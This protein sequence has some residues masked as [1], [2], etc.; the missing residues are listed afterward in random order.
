MLN[1]PYLLE[2][3]KKIEAP[4][5]FIPIAGA[6]LAIAA[7][8]YGIKTV[9][10][11]G[12]SGTHNVKKYRV[13]PTPPGSVLFFGHKLLLGD[14]PAHKIAEWHKELGPILKVKMG[15]EDWIYVADAGMAYELFTLEDSLTS[16][17]LHFMCGDAIYGGE[18][19]RTAFGH[20][21]AKWK[22]IRSVM[23]QFLSPSSFRRSYAT[24][25]EEA[26]KTVDLLIKKTR[27]HGSVD[28]LSFIR[29]NSINIILKTSLGQQGAK[30]LHDPL[31]R[32]LM[33]RDGVY[34]QYTTIRKPWSWMS[35][36][37]RLFSRETSP[38]N[39]L[40]APLQ[41]VIQRARKSDTD[42]VVKRLDL[43]KE[44]YVIDEH[45][46]AAIT[47]EL[48]VAG[49]DAL[50]SATAWTL[51]ILCHHP[52]VQQNLAREI[53]SFIIKHYRFPT[54]DDLPELPYYNT[55]LKECL[56]FRPPVY[57]G[58]PRK[59]SK[60][61]VCRN[62]LIPKGSTIVG[63]I[64]AISHD[65]YV[66]QDPEKFLPERF[67]YDSRTLHAGAYEGSEAHYAFGWKKRICPGISL[68]EAQIF[69]IVTKVMSRCTIEPA[70]ASNGQD[71]YPNLDDGRS[72]GATV[73]P[74]PFKLRFVE[75]SDR[76]IV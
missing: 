53:D 21:D 71:E 49:M 63:N 69:N 32:C 36:L 27:Q 22:D 62:Y 60:D 29:F 1:Y 50:S 68:A 51:A 65:N 41:R 14:I 43:L 33:N 56:R 74:G 4:G 28:P 19:G 46:I 66:V 42:N 70:I 24:L 64:H 6:V 25:Q 2:K 23:L 11:N 31:Y 75:R 17:S 47:G 76:T 16:N 45:N 13:I 10:R 58:I 57:F 48:L 12:W 55:L 52:D 30:S 39:A 67:Q 59:A 26:Q 7:A 38:M 3:Y 35:H 34:L 40:Y 73:V 8:M 18:E 5:P 15:N 37:H 44:E 9:L 20:D 54:F 61:V 72:V